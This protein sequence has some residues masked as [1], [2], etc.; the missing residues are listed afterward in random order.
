MQV[1]RER[2]IR[3]KITLVI[4]LISSAVLLLACVALF[5]FQAWSIKKTFTKQIAVTGEIVA[6]NVAVAVM[7][8]DEEQSAQTLAGLKAMQEIEGAWVTVSDGSRLATFG[9]DLSNSA[10]PASGIRVEGDRITLAQPV[11][12]DG[13]QHGTLYLNA[14]F[15]TV[16]SRLIRMYGGIVVLVLAVSLVLAFLL[17]SRFQGFVTTP[18]LRL[19]GTARRIAEDKDYAVRAE[20][21]GHDEV[22]L[23]TDAFNQM[24]TQIQSQDTALQ[25]AQRELMRDISERKAAEEALRLS[26]QKLLETSR[27]AG[28]AEVATGVLHNVGNVLNSVNVSAELVQETLRRSKAQNVMKAAQLLVN[29]SAD[30][31]DYLDNDVSGQKLPDY[32]AKL[33]EHLVT[34]NKRLLS[35]VESLSRN[36]DHI[37]H[38][39]AMQQSHAKVGGVFENLDIEKLVEDSIAMT[40]ESEGRKDFTIT[41]NFTRVP[42]IRVDRHRVL[43]ILINLIRNAK[44]AIENTRRTDKNITIHI[45]PSNDNCVHVIVTDNGSGISQENLTRVFGHGFTTRKDGHGFGLHSGAITAKEMGGSLQV[46]SEGE[47]CGAQ[48]ILVLPI[49]VKAEKR[50]PREVAT[51]A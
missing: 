17:S 4:V 14:N 27:L 10:M 9:H 15:S 23:L 6:N 31:V 50:L 43:Q 39:V 16:Y 11:I 28:M 22:G 20:S 12:R 51:I 21:A 44:Q 38:I 18:I 34:E 30:I 25:N 13:R 26:Q 35:E 29:R 36:I 46:R 47:G 32:L 7:F 37:K 2:S 49:A 40:L 41:R 42:A 3:Q 5:G 8:N 24:L 1:I 45:E 48:F 33:G 19:A